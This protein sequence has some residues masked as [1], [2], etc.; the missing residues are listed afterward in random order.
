MPIKRTSKPKLFVPE[1]TRPEWLTKKDI[2]GELVV[3]TV[4]GHD[5]K[6]RTSFGIGERTTVAIDVLTGEHEGR[7]EDEFQA[8]GLLAKQMGEVPVGET[9]AARIITG[10]T[11]TGQTWT[12]CDY[13]LSDED[14]ALVDEFLSK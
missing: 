7:H 10:E 9:A 5:E 4:T 8:F 13:E 2:A 11:K 14:S 1:P 3:F 6:Y 12:G